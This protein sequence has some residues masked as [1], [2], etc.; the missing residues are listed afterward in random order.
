C[1]GGLDQRGRA[2]RA[3]SEGIR[4]RPDGD[5]VRGRFVLTAEATVLKV[6]SARL[7]NATRGRAAA[8]AR[9]G[10]ASVEVAILAGQREVRAGVV[11]AVIAAPP[12]RIHEVGFS[13]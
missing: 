11:V 10:E 3:V 4:L 2:E 13:G 1:I 8:S 12:Q 5:E 7:R 9:A 6:R